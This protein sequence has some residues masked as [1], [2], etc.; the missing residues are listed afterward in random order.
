[1]NQLSINPHS[2]EEQREMMEQMYQLCEKQVKSYHKH[3]HMGNNSSVPIELAQDLI[4]SI[5]YTV[6]LAGGVHTNINIEEALRLGQKILENRLIQAKSML[7]LVMG[8]APQWQTECRWEA[9]R[10]LRHYLDNYDHLHMAHKYPENLYYPILVTPQEGIKGIDSCL[11]YLNILWIENR[12]MAGIPDDTLNRFWDHLPN[13]SSN[14]CE[15]L[16]IN[17]MGK[18]LINAGL[19]PLVFQPDEYQ[20]LL[21]VLLSATTETL[22]SAGNR[23][24]QWLE[25]NDE[26]AQK[27]V[28]SLIPLLKNWIGNNAKRVDLYS[29]FL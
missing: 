23:L 3:R 24:C 17:G 28:L 15:H 1:M 27:Y 19:T 8:T 20:Q 9:L 12:I 16:L 4:E 14:Q 11:F 5:V 13:G 21:S 22:Q 7:E 6:D 10:C 18:A 26:S 25:L 2:P 29:I